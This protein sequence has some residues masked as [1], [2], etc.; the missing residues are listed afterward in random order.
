MTDTQQPIGYLGIAEHFRAQIRLGRL[1]PGNALPTQREAAKKFDVA[2][3]TV[4]RAYQLL[5][6]EGYITA[7]TGS[8]T[9]VAHIQPVITGADRLDRMASGG[10][11]YGPE[12]TSSGH[13]ARVAACDLEWVTEAL[14]L[15]PGAQVVERR[16]IFRSQG[17]PAA[18]AMSYFRKD[19]LDLIPESLHQG[20]MERSVHLLYGD[21]TGEKILRSE[22]AVSSRL[23]T[24]E[25]LDALEVEVSPRGAAVPVTVLRVALH[26]QNTVLS[27]WEDVLAPGSWKTIPAS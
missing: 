22:E 3:T 12:E 15:E 21:R 16:R 5:K 2:L 9:V 6:S 20:Q 25:E 27:V 18:L 11:N 24:Q 10:P 19:I 8:R 17:K 26:T 4:N 14:G 23:A 13:A 1:T 7:S